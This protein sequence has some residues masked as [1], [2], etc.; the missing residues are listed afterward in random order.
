MDK[1]RQYKNITKKNI[2]ILLN[3]SKLTIKPNETISG[4][5]FLSSYKGLLQINGKNEKP[6]TFIHKENKIEEVVENQ[7]TGSVFEIEEHDFTKENDII[8]NTKRDFNTVIEYNIISEKGKFDM[9]KSRI[10]LSD[11]TFTIPI[12]IE[13]EDRQNNLTILLDYLSKN[14]TTN[15]IVCECSQQMKVKNFWKPEWSEF[16]KLLFVESKSPVFYKTKLLNIMAL[17]SK[18]EII[19]SYDSDVL[20]YPKAY[21]EA[22]NKIRSKELD[23]C[24]PFN[25]PLKHITK[26]NLPKLKKDLNL[27]SI[28]DVS[29]SKHPGVP[30]GGCFFMNLSKFKEAGMENENMISWGPE[31]QERLERVKILGYKVGS[32]DNEL[33]HMD[34]I[35]TQNS[36]YTNPFYEKNLQEFEKVKKMH[37][38]ELRNYV[39]MWRRNEK[40]SNIF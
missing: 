31:D 16:C 9:P 18:T 15:V 34:H 10:D 21:E 12:S 40:S 22:A 24:Y 30:P 13:S 17:K 3:G 19:V 26:E 5:S 27:K 37:K 7:I 35:I 39:N 6:K 4:P 33:Y 8:K 25:K 28:E 14:F 29:F 1:I 2:V 11:V 36:F 20:L 38:Q 23:F 32:L